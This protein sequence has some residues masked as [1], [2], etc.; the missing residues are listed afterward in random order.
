[1]PAHLNY[2]IP[3]PL[4]STLLPST[5]LTALHTLH[6]IITANPHMTSFTPRP[7]SVTE[8]VDDAFFRADDPTARLAAFDVIQRIPIIPGASKSVEVPCVMQTFEGGVRC[9]S[10][11][12]G[13]TVWSTW[14]VRR[15]GEGE[16]NGGGGGMN[17]EWE[18]VEDARV[19]CGTMV[20]PFVG[21]SFVSAHKEILKRLVDAVNEKEMRRGDRFA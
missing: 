14:F 3:Q 7:L 13:V 6:P 8:V 2:T 17:G 18:L 19:E 9:R 1:M 10:I 15:A 20:K 4:P 21:R 5:L 16:V 11:A 12:A